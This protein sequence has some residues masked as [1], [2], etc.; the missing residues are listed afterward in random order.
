MAKRTKTKPT[1]GQ[2]GEPARM[3]RPEYVPS[4]KDKGAVEAYVR[5]GAPEQIIADILGI[6]LNTLRKH[7]RHEI[8]HGRTKFGAAL[9]QC[10]G[11]MALGRP[12]VW[13]ELDAN[14]KRYL[15]QD[16]LKPDGAMVRYCLS[17]LFAEQGWGDKL[18]LSG[19]KDNPL[20]TMDFSTMTDKQLEQFLAFAERK[21]AE[22]ARLP[23]GASIN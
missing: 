23:D 19:D 13:S 17:S 11:Q 21:R 18:K 22:I 10:A 7:Y 16:E 2:P 8:D 12:A 1:N 14:G 6:A 5:F 20:F 4:D 15:V 9:S 3:G